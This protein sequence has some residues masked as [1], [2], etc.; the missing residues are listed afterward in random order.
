VR[1]PVGSGERQ[2]ERGGVGNA[3]PIE[4][5]RFDVLFVRKRLDLRGRAMDQHHADVQ[6]TQHRDVEQ[7]V[8]KI[9]VR[10][11]GAINADDEGPLPELRNV[12]EDAPQ[13]S[14]FRSL[15]VV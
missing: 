2:L 14:R 4:V 3:V 7:D 10:D 11:D 13:V 5:G 15:V 12:L 1:E 6:R 9:L 8:G